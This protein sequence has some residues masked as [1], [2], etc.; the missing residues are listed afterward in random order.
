MD[1]RTF[2]KTLGLGIA[3]LPVVAGGPAGGGQYN[4]AGTDSP[5]GPI[6][7]PTIKPGDTVG[8]I[9]PSSPLADDEGYAIAEA[10][11]K[12]LGLQLRWGKNVGKRTGYLAG[13]DE[14]R[15]ADLHAMFA[16]PAVKA[17]VCLRGG[18]GAGRL[19]DKLDYGLIAQNPKIFMGYS[20]IT[21]LHQAIVT[22]AGLVT[23]HGAVANSR[24]TDMVFRQFRQLFFDGQPPVYADNQRPVRTLT[25]GAAE[26]KLLGGNLT[27][28]TGIAGSRYY[29]DFTD[30]ILFIE[31]IG[32]EPYRIDRMFSQLDLSGALKQIKGF[33]FGRCTDCEASDPRSSLPLDRIVDHYIKPLGIPA[34]QGALIGHMDEQFIL[35]VGARVCMDANQG[36]ITVMENIFAAG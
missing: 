18:S 3:T 34:Y 35:P 6:R 36:T 33:V 10:N 24:W 2:I 25:P 29:P 13:T 17:I 28:L 5:P 4:P 26:G 23:F 32:E 20:D 31:E 30:S 16:D 21:A 11:I 22:Q 12:A 1:K 9:T 15:I 7:P 8:I 27:V 19:L 14:E